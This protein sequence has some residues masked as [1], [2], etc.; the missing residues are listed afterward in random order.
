MLAAA[1]TARWRYDFPLAARLAQAALDAGAGFD[2]ELLAAQLASL[3]GRGADA[4]TRLAALAA[5]AS[6]D[7]QRALVAI[8]RLDNH[9]YYLGHIVEAL[10]IAD[11]VEATIADPIWRNEITAKRSGLLLAT[12]GPRAAAEAAQP[13]LGQAGGRSLVWACINASYSLGRLGRIDEALAAADRGYTANR[14]LKQPIEWYPWYHLFHRGEALA[15]AGRMAEAEALAE[16]QYRHGLAEKSPEAQAFF[17]WQL[18]KRVGEQ[19]HVRSSVR[20]GQEAAA[21]FHQLDRPQFVHYCLG[22]LAMAYALSGQPANAHDVLVHLDGLRLPPTFFMGVDLLQARAWAAVSAGDAPAGCRLLEEAAEVGH[23]IGDLVGAAAALH[24]LAR[25]GRP[26]VVVSRMTELAALI[27]GHL[28][29]ARAVHVQCLCRG[30]AGGLEAVASAFE[31]VGADLLAAEAVAD[32]AIAW[33]RAGDSRRAARTESRLATL[34]GRCEGAITPA[35][36][37]VTS[38]AHI[39]PAER[40]TALL[41]AVGRSNKEIAQQLHLS[42]RTVES[43]LQHVYEKLG[44]RSRTELATTLEIEKPGPAKLLGH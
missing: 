43:Y 17:A 22:Y 34:A 7:A 33:R 5:R 28:A 26:K 11:E 24:A 3:Q 14:E 10:T 9:V 18:C 13:L 31:T 8:T 37:A 16:E 38:R 42:V 25:L 1:V 35:L 30:D 44:I 32:A 36:Q 6:D 29:S 40:E 15:H 21:L 20:H 27:E 12:N 19:G 39:T 2:A 23:N 4:E 41:A